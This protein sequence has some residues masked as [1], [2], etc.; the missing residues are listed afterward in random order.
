MLSLKLDGK[1]VWVTGGS[2]G[3]G[4]ATAVA[5]AD[6]GC[7]VAV[8][9]RES[10]K[11][12]EAVVAEIQGK[13]RKAIAVKMDVSNA[14]SCEAA[15]AEVS[16]KLGKCDVLVNNAGVTADNLFLMLEEPD[17]AKVMGTNVMGVVH[18]TKLVLRDMMMKRGGR[19]IN[20]SSAAGTKGGRGQSNYAASKGAV[21]AM[22][23]SLAVELSKRNITVNCVAPGV[24]ETD[25]SAEVRKLAEQEILDRQL[26][27][28]FGKPE[29]VAGWVVFLASCYGDFV[30]GQTIHV[31]GGLKMP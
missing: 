4:R 15:Y 28:R 23:R 22:S 31:D 19:I 6:V 10:A 14:A 13:G 26:V 29:E 12:A 20:L 5:F 25:M 24:I 8:G 17:W 21:E 18:C 7:D 11:G 9:Y 16:E 2:R 3:I 27:K 1:I 30:T